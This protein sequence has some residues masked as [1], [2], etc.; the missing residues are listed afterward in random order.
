[1]DYRQFFDAIDTQNKGYITIEDLQRTDHEGIDQVIQ[2]LQLEEGESLT[3]DQ[4]RAS[5]EDEAQRHYLEQ[6]HG[7]KFPY[8]ED[9]CTIDRFLSEPKLL[10]GSFYTSEAFFVKFN[11]IFS[12]F[13]KH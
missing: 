8:F 1:M 9:F 13:K 10:I 4:F 5:C 12:S 11:I 2:T 6:N 7:K 3:F